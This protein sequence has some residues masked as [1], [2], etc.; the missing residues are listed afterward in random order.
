[1]R[2]LVIVIVALFLISCEQ[3]NEINDLR[4]IDVESNVGKS[5]Q[6]L[7]S[8]VAESIEYI[9]LET[10]EESFLG[11]PRRNQFVYENDLLFVCQKGDYF[12]IFN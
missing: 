8:E 2:E 1:M 9:P 4:V 6:V 12:K 11:I 7:L 3:E 10:T 5:R